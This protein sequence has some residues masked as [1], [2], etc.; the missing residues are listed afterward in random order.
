M[1]LIIEVETKSKTTLIEAKELIL[2][3]LGETSSKIS[4]GSA[5]KTNAKVPTKPKVEK[6][7]PKPTPEG[8][9]A[10]EPTI[11]L[12]ELKELAKSAVIKTDRITVKNTIAE[13]APKLSEVKEADYDKLAE[14]LKALGE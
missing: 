1:K 4:N 13:F 10:P 7:I 11:T 14:S 9:N 2:Q 8:K 3:L 5:H 6:E 12:G